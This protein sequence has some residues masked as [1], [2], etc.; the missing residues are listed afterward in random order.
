MALPGVTA[1]RTI[2]IQTMLDPK[3]APNIKQFFINDS[4]GD[5]TNI[6]FVQA[7]A[8]SGEQC[9]EQVLQYV[10]VSGIKTIQKIAWRSATWLGIAWDIV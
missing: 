10:T 1:F 9:L 4:D 5:P 3:N 6:Y 2:T 7:A 8:A